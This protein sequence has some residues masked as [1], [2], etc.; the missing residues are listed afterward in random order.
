MRLYKAQFP[1]KPINQ[2]C[3]FVAS[4]HHSHSFYDCFP[5]QRFLEITL[6]FRTSCN[7]YNLHLNLNNNFGAF[8]FVNLKILNADFQS[9]KHCNTA[10]IGKLFVP[11]KGARIEAIQ[12]FNCNNF[13]S[14]IAALEI[15]AAVCLFH[16]D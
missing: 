11:R 3:P 16:F 15:L 4:S 14:A 13:D 1:F 5:I 8:I 7:Y 2:L 10:T 6:R 9:C 12:Y